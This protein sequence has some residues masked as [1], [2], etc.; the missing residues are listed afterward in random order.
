[1]I[2]LIL[3]DDFFVN[4]EDQMVQDFLG[5]DDQFTDDDTSQTSNCPNLEIA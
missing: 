5:D 2:G 1:M 4:E 3:K